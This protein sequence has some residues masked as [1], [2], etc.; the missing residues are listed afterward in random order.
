MHRRHGLAAIVAA[1]SVRR[2]GHGP[3]AVHRL[4]PRVHGGTVCGVAA[5]CRSQSQ[6]GD[7]PCKSHA[8]TSLGCGSLEVKNAALFASFWSAVACHRFHTPRLAG[9][10]RMR[11]PPRLCSAACGVYPDD[12]GRDVPMVS[13]VAAS[14]AVSASR[15]QPR[16]R[17]FA[18]VAQT[19]QDGEKTLPFRGSELNLSRT[20]PR[21]LRHNRLAY[22]GLQPLRKAFLHFSA[23]CSLCLPFLA[24]RF[25]KT[26]KPR[27]MR[28][29]AR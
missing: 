1:A 3:A 4:L 23:A 25:R 19:S 2:A 8:Q 14:R 12:F 21:E 18:L 24:P 9:A 10:R 7:G 28:P 20:E 16:G 17:L 29:P 26:F 27:K 5:E 22:I 11:R 13:I 6:R 15:A